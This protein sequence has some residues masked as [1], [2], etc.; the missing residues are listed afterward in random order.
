MGRRNDVK[1]VGESFLIS[2]SSL[3]AVAAAAF[4][5]GIALMLVTDSARAI[6][7][8][9]TGLLTFN[10]FPVWSEPEFGI[11]TMLFNSLALTSWTCLWVWSVGVMIAAYL[12]SY[13]TNWER[14]LMLR[15]FEYISGVPSVVLGM[16]G[17]LVLAKL[18]LRFGAWTGQN[19]LNASIM[20]FVLTL[21]TMTSLTFQSLEK[22]PREI[23]EGAIS[24]GAR[25][26]SVVLMELRYAAPGVMAAMLTVLNRIF[27]ETMIV[28]MVAG[29][30]NMLVRS[31]FDPVRPLTA[32]IGSEM[33][34]V[35]VGSLH[36]SVL[37][38]MGLLLLII[39]LFLT[40]TVNFIIRR[41][42]RLIRG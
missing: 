15:T 33:S 28:L 38:F 11:L 18:F 37:F 6:K 17:V 22:V 4:L 14:N 39:S 41:Y 10:W 40:T 29:G 9:G 7:E 31:L 24:L 21:P 36:Y 35:G 16:F 25:D 27:G 30:S 13:A 1:K 19:F 8:V 26:I 3:A 5:V 32:V 2:I 23:K 20:L 12:H 34:E 42:E